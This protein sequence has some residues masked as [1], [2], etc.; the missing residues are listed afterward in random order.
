MY[1]SMGYYLEKLEQIK[2]DDKQ[3]EAYNSGDRK[4]VV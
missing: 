4:S 1:Y 3:L 2:K